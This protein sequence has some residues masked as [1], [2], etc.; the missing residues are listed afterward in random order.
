MNNFDLRKY[1]AEGGIKAKLNENLDPDR[2]NLISKIKKLRDYGFTGKG[3]DYGP[4]LITV[5]TQGGEREYF[6][7]GENDESEDGIF[8]STN[9]EEVA[10]FVI[11]Y[12]NSGN[13]AEGEDQDLEKVALLFLENDPG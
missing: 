13:L 4:L 6:V 11:N 7:Y 5:F 2:E 3:I 10:D 12:G 9:P 1:L 8:N